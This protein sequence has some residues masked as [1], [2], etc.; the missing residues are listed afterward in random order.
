MI[1]SWERRQIVRKIENG[2]TTTQPHSEFEQICCYQLQ[3]TTG[4]QRESWGT[5][6][7]DR[8]SKYTQLSRT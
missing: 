8:A 5:R 4:L 1:S 2:A 6:K 3:Q 7:Q